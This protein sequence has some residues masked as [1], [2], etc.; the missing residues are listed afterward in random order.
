MRSGSAASADMT[1]DGDVLRYALRRLPRL[2]LLSAAVGAL[3]YL[4]S[5]MIAPSYVS[6]AQLS[7]LA[8]GGSNPFGKADGQDN[9]TVRMDKEA[10]NTHV[11][12]LLSPDLARTI[13]KEMDLASK[14]EFNSKLGSVDKLS[15]L[16]RVAGIGAP[17][18]GET[19][20][21]QVLSQYFRRLEVYTPK[22]SRLI[23]VR[24][25]STDPEL[26]AIIANKLSETYRNSLADQTQTEISE[27]QKV[28]EPKIAALKG[29]VSKA[30]REIEAFR[31][32]SDI[33][34][35]GQTSPGLNNQQL[36]ELTAELSRV[37]AERSEAD[38]RSRSSHDLLKAGS[39]DALPDVQKSPLISNL[40]QQ[41]VTLER[42]ISENAVANLPGHPVSKKL[43]AELEGL[44]KQIGAEIAKVI[45][46]IDKEA[47]VAALRE[48]SVSKRL[49]EM[50]DSVVIKGPNEADLRTLE[51]SAK[52]KR[53][54]LDRLETQFESNRIKADS[55]SVGVE[56]QIV[57]KAQ[58]SSVPVSPNKIANAL[59]ATT[60]TLLLALAL[61]VTK[62]LIAGARRQNAPASYSDPA[63]LREYP[64]RRRSDPSMTAA[65]ATATLAGAPAAV[66]ID[67]APRLPTPAAIPEPVTGKDHSLLKKPSPSLD[68][69]VQRLHRKAAG[70]LGFRTLIAGDAPAINEGPE[71][72]ALAKALAVKGKAVLLLDWAPR[73]KSIVG[74]LG[75]KVEPGLTGLLDGRSTFE[76]TI[77]AVPGS[78]IHIITAG[79][80]LSN[81]A[82]LEDAQKLNMLLDALDEAYDHIVVACPFEDARH[83]F[84][85]TEGRF[86]A[87]LTISEAKRRTS[88][89]DDSGEMFLGFEVTDIELA[90]LERA[91]SKPDV[92]QRIQR[93]AL[94]GD[95]IKAAR[96]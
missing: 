70:P 50:K 88:A 46:G 7:I 87:G 44:R 74:G 20:E 45:D 72:L 69:V 81:P 39:A 78:D 62:G 4:I 3:A 95:R 66:A 2:L 57:T 28:L 64:N 93:P 18:A 19:E 59:F 96:L 8:K 6:E 92:T 36:I 26:A 53:A 84:E 31:G 16:L 80:P 25:T 5:S 14:V 42:R 89:L 71:A 76:D 43:Q 83:L 49:K 55:K 90:T 67:P 52:N 41:R 82:G 13:A 22:E 40:V 37:K 58:P 79:A 47:K 9:V 35:G 38:A 1:D 85:A 75:L 23:G 10:V 30:E 24:F 65:A 54:E 94:P 11:R 32:K 48:E 34:S 17:R 56:A 61:V 73:G 77:R 27:V 33:F 15:G 51:A 91:A 12:A 63:S 29:E 86:D 68:E 60:A 21:D